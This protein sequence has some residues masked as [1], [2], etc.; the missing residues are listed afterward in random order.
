[1]KEPH[2]DKPTSRIGV[3]AHDAPAFHGALCRALTVDQIG[4][5]VELYRAITERCGFD[6]ADIVREPGVSFNPKP[7]RVCQILMKNFGLYEAVVIGAGIVA[8][9]GPRGVMATHERFPEQATLADEALRVEAELPTSLA[10]F[11]STGIFLA[12]LID[13]CRHL[14]LVRL[15]RQELL[16]ELDQLQEQII[17][18]IP[19]NPYAF[20]RQALTTW[21]LQTRRSKRWGVHG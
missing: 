16:L 1:M 21:V 10:P 4:V 6:D 13:R 12:C 20:A 7:A 2:H 15:D 18:F 17:P 19:E 14:H 11:A 3:L 5:L 9:G 8:A